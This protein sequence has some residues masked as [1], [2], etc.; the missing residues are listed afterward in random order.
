[1]ATTEIRLLWR[2]GVAAALTLMV[3]AGLALAAAD[4]GSAAAAKKKPHCFKPGAE[5]TFEYC[6]VVPAGYHF[7][8][9]LMA[10]V[11]FD[12]K[13]LEKLPVTVKPLE[14]TWEREALR[15]AATKEGGEQTTVP[16]KVT[17]KLDADCPL[18]ALKIPVVIDVFYCNVEEGWC[19]SSHYDT[20]L[21]VTVSTCEDAQAK[22]SLK[23]TVVAK[24]EA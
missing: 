21:K 17:A 22:G 24:P 12:G 3:A 1:M 6:F 13:K 4:G 14:Y 23:V 10:A 9:E 16:A 8:D 18:G 19:T 11:A 7:A 2:L 5:V 20:A 15:P